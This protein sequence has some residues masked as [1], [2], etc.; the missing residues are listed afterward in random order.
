MGELMVK[1]EFIIIVESEGDYQIAATLAERVLREK[2]DWLYPDLLSELFQWCG[3]L[4]N[5]NYSRWQ[6]FKQIISELK[7]LG[8]HIPKY[9]GH[10]QEGNSL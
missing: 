8:Y 7:K 4:E 3:L 2:I 9:I 1:D 10:T 6:D 5:T